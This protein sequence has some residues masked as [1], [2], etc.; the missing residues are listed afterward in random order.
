MATMLEKHLGSSSNTKS[1]KSSPVPESARFGL[2]ERGSF[3]CVTGARLV[4]G[5][6][7]GASVVMAWMQ[8]AETKSREESSLGGGSGMAPS[9]WVLYLGAASKT[10]FRLSPRLGHE[11]LTV[12]SRE[13]RG[14][15][16]A[17]SGC[18]CEVGASGAFS[19]WHLLCPPE[20]MGGVLLRNRERLRLRDRL[21]R[22][23]VFEM[24]VA[25]RGISFLPEATK[26]CDG[27]SS[28]SKFE[29]AKKLST[30]E[31]SPS[32]HTPLTYRAYRGAEMSL[33]FG[34][35][36]AAATCVPKIAIIGGAV[37]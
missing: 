19:L 11:R 13:R 30:A 23:R 29:G 35:G 24:P 18:V 22:R 10:T 12:G 17:L 21:G 31:G 5:A 4:A 25:L 20:A 37:V 28:G 16:H 7:L 9:S 2:T 27:G 33:V 15:V 14:E 1:L 26:V 36:A 32:T 8:E 3:F 34:G 6:G